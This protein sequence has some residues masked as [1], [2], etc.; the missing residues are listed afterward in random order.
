MGWCLECHRAPEKYVRPKEEVFNLAY[1]P[2]ANQLELGRSLVKSYHIN[3]DAMANC[4]YCH[5]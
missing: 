4:S 3:A 2:P 1:E 5:R